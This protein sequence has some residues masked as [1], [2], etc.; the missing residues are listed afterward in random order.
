M[1]KELELIAALASFFDCAGVEPRTISGQMANDTV[2]DALMQF[3]NRLR[4]GREPQR[5]QRVLVHDLNR[6]GHLSAQVMGALKNYVAIDPVTER[7][8]VEHFAYLDDNPHAVD[9]QATCEII[10]RTRPDLIV[11]GRSVIIHREPVQ[12]IAEFV[13]GLYGADNP[14]RPLIMYDGAHV[15]GLLG[16]AYQ[17]PLHEGADVITGSTHKTFFGPQRGVILSNITPG[18]AFELFWRQVGS[19]TFPGHLSNHHLGTLLGMLGATYEMLAFQREYPARVIEN[20]QAFARGLAGNGLALEGDPALGYTQ[21]HQVLLAYHDD[22]SFAA[23]SGVRMGTQEMTRYG[24]AVEGF[25]E[26]AD[27]I[28]AIVARSDDGVDEALAARVR[29]L[30]GRHTRMHYC[31]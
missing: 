10:E 29:A 16:D 1:E 13:H 3:R 23:A 11:F 5:L 2:Y 14:L 26:L 6:G 21:T 31:F 4:R 19:R 25:L 7:P 22:H 17:K 8:A 9:A 30:R 12:P 15:L 20:A 24:M 28:A 27:L 18:H